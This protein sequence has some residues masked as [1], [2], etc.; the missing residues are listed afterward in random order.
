MN[1]V[2]VIYS[3]QCPSNAHFIREIG[4][5]SRPYGVALEAINVFEEH[6]R[7]QEYLGDTPVG[8][9]KHLFITVFIDGRWI[10]G[11]PG[12]PRFKDDFLRALEEE[13]R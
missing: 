1:E 13:T 2:T 10:P 9:T 11:H 5:W 8:R 6:E 7:A 4:E 12:N 3:P